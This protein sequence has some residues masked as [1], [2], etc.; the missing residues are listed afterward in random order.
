MELILSLE[1]F[2]RRCQL[3]HRRIIQRTSPILVTLYGI[4]NLKNAWKLVKKGK[5]EGNIDSR[6][7]DKSK[8][9]KTLFHR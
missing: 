9:S 5:I 7:S 3:P 8:I 6:R 2:K 1:K 4:S